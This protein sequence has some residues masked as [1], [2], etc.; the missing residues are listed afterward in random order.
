M[1]LQIE[2]EKKKQLRLKDKKPRNYTK[3]NA[4]LFDYKVKG[5]FENVV[6]I[7]F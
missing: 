1:P 2:G 7:V 3:L 6:A 4:L 5:C